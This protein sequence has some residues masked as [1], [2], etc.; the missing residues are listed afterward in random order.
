MRSRKLLLLLA[1]GAA[2]ATLALGGGVAT[3]ADPIVLTFD[4][5]FT[6]KNCAPAQPFDVPTG[7]QTIDVV[8]T[9]TVAAPTFLGAEPQTTIERKV[10]GTMAGRISTKRIFVDWPGFTSTQTSIFSRSE[11]GGDS[12]RLLIDHTCDAR[13]RPNCD[14]GGGGDSE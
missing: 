2:A 3:A 10:S 1:G 4:G 6:A 14:T 8:A 11:D 13:S 12:F 5:A 9:A 7:E